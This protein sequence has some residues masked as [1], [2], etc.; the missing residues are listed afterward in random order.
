MIHFPYTFVRDNQGKV[1]RQQLSVVIRTDKE[2]IEVPIKAVAVGDE[3]LIDQFRE[4][5]N[6]LVKP[7]VA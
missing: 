6:E 1:I 5:L 2:K 3:H 4:Q 7:L